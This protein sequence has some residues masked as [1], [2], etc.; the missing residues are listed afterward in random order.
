MPFQASLDPVSD[1]EVPMR[2]P[3][4]TPGPPRPPTPHSSSSTP[5]P[6]TGNVSRC[7]VV[8]AAENLQSGNAS[9]I[10]QVFVSPDNDSESDSS[11]CS[12]QLPR[13]SETFDDGKIPKPEGEVGRPG[14]GGYNLHDSLG[15]QSN[16]FAR[17]RVRFSFH[18]CLLY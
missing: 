15:W 3:T 14:R 4:P 12:F 7:Q 16:Q 8:F 6:S 9:Q 18:V 2:V 13:P 1:Q 17:L 11:T 10:S 5:L